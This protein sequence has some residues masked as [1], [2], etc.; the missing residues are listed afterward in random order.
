MPASPQL[1]P[2]VA[3]ADGIAMGERMDVDGGDEDDPFAPHPDGD[4]EQRHPHAR[5][6]GVVF[7]EP[8][9]TYTWRV[10]EGVTERAPLSASALSTNN[11]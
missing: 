8:T 4:L 1:S 2:S 5:D 10:R 9:H 6:E 3:V 7:D 11:F